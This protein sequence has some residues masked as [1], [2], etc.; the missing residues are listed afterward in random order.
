MHLL[1]GCGKICSIFIVVR[2]KVVRK[3]LVVINWLYSSVCTAKCSWSAWD[4]Y[5]VWSKVDLWSLSLINI[6]STSWLAHSI[7]WYHIWMDVFFFT[8][9]NI[10]DFLT[11]H[12][13]GSDHSG[14]VFNI[15]S[16]ND[17][18][19]NYRILPNIISALLT[20]LEIRYWLLISYLEVPHSVN[21][22]LRQMQN[23]VSMKP[24]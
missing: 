21:M 10:M 8:I 24:N 20:R 9:L 7:C 23:T 11:L 14:K 4:V 5:Y 1:I 3:L 2:V 12:N 17:K 6:S 16:R 13:N 19:L 15:V 18:V 22:L